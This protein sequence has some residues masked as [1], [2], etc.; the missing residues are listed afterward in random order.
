MAN[1]AYYI[2]QPYYCYSY[3]FCEGWWEET[4]GGWS[5][6]TDATGGTGGSGG[7]GG[8]GSTPPP[9]GGSVAARNQVQQG[10]EPGWNPGGGG[11]NPPPPP[12]HQDPID[13]ILSKYSR[14]FRHIGDS[15]YNNHSLPGNKE[16][17][18]A[19]ARNNTTNDTV[20]L[21]IRTD[22]DS[23]FVT[24]N[25]STP[26][27]SLLFIWHSHVSASLNTADRRTFSPA[28][29][30]Y[31]RKPQCLK[32]NF[33][34]FAD[35]GNKQYALVIPDVAKAQAFFAANDLLHINENFWTTGGGNMQQIDE[36]CVKNVIGSA[37]A[38]GIAFYVSANSPDFSTWTLLN[39]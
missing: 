15:I 14:K 4:G 18:F 27:H 38:N 8:G 1:Y 16:Y 10:C 20:I 32:L 19:G 39:P 12:P 17:F 9:C 13:T 36:R 34:S 30:H 6:G 24:P 26:G 25:L 22:N 7:R 21:N 23:S 37:A 2:G 29:I 11:G 31:L 35:C 28:D 33:T 3:S 5:G